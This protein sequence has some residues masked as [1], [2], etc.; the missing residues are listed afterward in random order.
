M[1]YKDFMNEKTLNPSTHKEWFTH[2][3][4]RQSYNHIRL[5]LPNMFHYLDHPRIPKT[6]NGIESFF[7]HLKENISL[8]RGMSFHHYQNYVKWYL[9]FRDTENKQKKNHEK[10]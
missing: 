6:T 1:E 7:G 8:H 9:Y 4:L 2:K 10:L 5:A 3:K